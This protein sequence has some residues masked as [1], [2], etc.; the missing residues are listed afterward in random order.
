MKK[1][2]FVGIFVAF[3]LVFNLAYSQEPGKISQKSDSIKT[4]TD[5]IK[6]KVSSN[7]E[8]KPTK[9]NLKIIIEN[10]KNN[11]GNLIVWIFK[12]EDAFPVKPEKAYKT[13]IVPSDSL[14]DNQI[15]I[16]SLRFD[17]YAVSVVHD[18]DG[19]GE[20]D[21]NFLGMPK[22]GV[23]VSNN[24]KGSFGPPKFKDAKFNF[25]PDI[26]TLSIEINY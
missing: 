4:E 25:N 24:A 6:Q 16:D 23:G 11:K 2:I 19:N 20:M 21:T 15:M 8:N 5:S 13:K 9:G 22:E 26:K 1:N 3:I 7:E 14:A 10:L 18:E 12:D 17:T